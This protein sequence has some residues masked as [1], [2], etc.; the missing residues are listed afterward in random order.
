MG[1]P[2]EQ[3]PTSE[4]DETAEGPFDP[5][6][7]EA[8]E[9]REAPTCP[10]CLM[11]GMTSLGRRN[12]VETFELLERLT[13][14]W[15]SMATVLLILPLLP[16]RSAGKLPLSLD[17]VVWTTTTTLEIDISSSCRTRLPRPD[18]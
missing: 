8:K 14:L 7:A 18:T 2:Q 13:L 9:I 17:D 15:Q 6:E 5:D 11:P 3:P 16:S 4:A 10:R 12:A 1:V